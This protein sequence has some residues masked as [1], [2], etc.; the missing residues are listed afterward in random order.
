M[1]QACTRFWHT[2]IFSLQ[3][4]HS[5]SGQLLAMHASGKQ[6]LR[7][8]N[9]FLYLW[10]LLHLHKELIP[11][12]CRMLPQGCVPDS[13]QS[14]KNAAL[15]R[16]PFESVSMLTLPRSSCLL[17]SSIEK[18]GTEQSSV[19]GFAWAAS[20]RLFTT[21]AWI[22]AYWRILGQEGRRYLAQE[23]RLKIKWR[24]SRNNIASSIRNAKPWSH[25]SWVKWLSVSDLT[26][27]SA[28]SST[29]YR[30]SPLPSQPSLSAS[31]S[32]MYTPEQ[33]TPVKN[34]CIFSSSIV[35]FFR[36]QVERVTA[37]SGSAVSNN[38]DCLTSI[39]LSLLNIDK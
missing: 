3:I 17:S 6:L 35:L 7:L 21:C 23:Q 37:R 29:L 15:L 16:L 12:R 9:A 39:W 11:L 33:F 32:V 2:R 13:I 34:C 10:Y 24:M 22:L 14:S 18:V 5:F 28:A 38:Q 25:H 19:I 26:A 20:M 4:A 27:M 36:F 31:W 1:V 30:K 8:W